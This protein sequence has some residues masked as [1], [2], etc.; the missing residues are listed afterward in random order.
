MDVGL[1][2]KLFG[3]EQHWH[4]PCTVVLDADAS[5]QNAGT[6]MIVGGGAKAY[7]PRII[8]GRVNADVVCLLKDGAGLL[9]IQQQRIRQPTG[10][11]I[12]KQTLTAADPSHIV[13]I[14][15]HDIAPLTALG[16]QVPAPKLSGSHPGLGTRPK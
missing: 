1:L 7:A 9:V 8:S 5:I 15:F 6:D 11:E 13:A 10:E 14:E 2:Q 12:I 4:G 3:T 16:L